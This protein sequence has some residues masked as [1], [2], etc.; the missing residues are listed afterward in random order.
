MT[1]VCFAEDV[2]ICFLFL[3]EHCLQG[4]GFRLMSDINCF[5]GLYIILPQISQQGKLL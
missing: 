3:P 2:D 1:D 4:H 5:G